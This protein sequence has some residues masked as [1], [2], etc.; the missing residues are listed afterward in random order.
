LFVP[1]GKREALQMCLDRDGLDL[2]SV[3]LEA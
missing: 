3:K 2:V 1:K